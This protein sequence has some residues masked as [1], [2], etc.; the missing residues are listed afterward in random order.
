MY[1]SE[2]EQTTYFSSIYLQDQI[3]VHRINDEDYLA[4]HIDMCDTLYGLMSDALEDPTQKL[5][6]AEHEDKIDLGGYSEPLEKSLL[7]HDDTDSEL[8]SC[9]HPWRGSYSYKGFEAKY[10]AG[11]IHLSI[12]PIGIDTG[13]VSGTGMDTI[14]DF[15]VEGVLLQ[16]GFISFNKQYLSHDKTAWR[17]QGS[18]DGTRQEI[19]GVWGYMDSGNDNFNVRLDDDH[20]AGSFEY[21]NSPVRS[22]LFRPTP[23]ELTSNKPQALWRFAIKTI[24]HK[25]NI[26]AGRFSWGYLQERRGIRKRLVELFAR[27]NHLLNSGLASNVPLTTEEADEL[28]ELVSMCSEADLR[29]YRSLAVRLQRRSTIFLYVCYTRT[30]PFLTAY[31]LVANTAERVVILLAACGLT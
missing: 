25:I 19:S 15:T 16:R 3:A 14:G 7:F 30:T 20:I 17:F 11:T 10:S 24:R 12:P 21:Y 18:I 6:Y 29:C 28:S 1:T 23:E 2:F 13:T 9:S 4:S 22:R 26:R 31:A 5:S 8:G 27:R